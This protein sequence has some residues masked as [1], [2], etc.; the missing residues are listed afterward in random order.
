MSTHHSSKNNAMKNKTNI[1][2]AG[3][4]L[5]GVLTVTVRL[6]NNDSATATETKAPVIRKMA[7]P[8]SLQSGNPGPQAREMERTEATL[9]SEADFDEEVSL[10]GWQRRFHDLLAEKGNRE[11]AVAVVLAEIDA[12]FGAWVGERLAPLASLPP[13]ERYDPLAN[14]EESVRGGAAAIV[15][16][17]E[18]RNADHVS[19]AA[20]ALET[21]AAEMQYAESAP[22]PASRLAMLRLDKE[23]QERMDGLMSITD[24][25]AMSK[26]MDELNQWY[27]T[28]IAKVFP[29]G[30]AEAEIR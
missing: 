18:V 1:I 3:L 26:A 4:F 22:D 14:I 12:V 10:T 25:A 8:P 28:A 13:G 7:R 21:I 16:L 29:E 23:R 5:T 19:V 17:L 24:E 2:L 20:G 6:S 9:I 11:E 15:E 30:P 27:E